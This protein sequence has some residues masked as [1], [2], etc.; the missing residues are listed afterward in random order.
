MDESLEPIWSQAEN[1]QNAYE[2]DDGV[3]I[4]TESICGENVKQMVLPTC[5]REEM[6]NS[7]TP[8]VRPENPF[9]VWS[10]NC[11]GPLEPSSR[12]GHKYIICEVDICTR[13]AEAVPVRNIKEKTIRGF[14]EDIHP[15]WVPK[16]ICT[17]QGTNFTAEF[18]EAFK[19]VLGIA[20]RFIT[21]GYLESMGAA[22]RWSRTVKEMLNKNIQ[23]NGNNWDSHFPYLMFAY[24]EVPRSTT[25]SRHTNLFM[26]DY[27]VC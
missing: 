21:P 25:P 27:Q 11:I 10:V 3:L 5:K 1:K 18:T 6:K 26:V 24:R 13:W 23:E 20:P 4:H 7:H 12:R 19:D 15:T 8:I 17:D 16:N 22:E 9:E 14:N 2:I